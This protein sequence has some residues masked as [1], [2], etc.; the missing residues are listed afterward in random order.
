[1][2]AT[3]SDFVSIP[4]PPATT[5]WNSSGQVCVELDGKTILLELQRSL[6]QLVCKANRI[7]A[8]LLAQGW[9]T[10]GAD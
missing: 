4:A 8:W 9:Q 1:M 10:A 3:Q 2:Q 5:A 6:E 7:E